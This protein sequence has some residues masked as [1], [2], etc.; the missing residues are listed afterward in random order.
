MN[1][2]IQREMRDVVHDGED[3]D[4]G[5]LRLV[6]RSWRQ[7]KVARVLVSRGFVVFEFEEMF[8]DVE[9]ENDATTLCKR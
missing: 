1:E 8:D 6:M 5:G 9:E 2:C 3:S 7:E 4:N